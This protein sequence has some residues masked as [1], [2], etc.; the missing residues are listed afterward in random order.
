MNYITINHSS[1]TPLY[2]QLKASIVNAINQGI[3]SSG[4]KVPTEEELCERF[5]I[6]RPVIRQAYS[7]LSSEGILHRVKGIGTFIREKE[8]Q[9]HF[10]QTISTYEEDIRRVGLSPEVKI[11]QREIIDTAGPFQT[12]LNLP[13]EAE[14][15]H[16]RFLYLGNKVPFCLVDS[17]VPHALFPFLLS[18]ALESTPLYQLLESDYSRIIVQAIRTVDAIIASD[19]EAVTLNI[20]KGAAIHEVKT[21]ATDQNETILEYSRA[22]YPGERNAFDVIIYR[23]QP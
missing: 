8:I 16:I 20:P 10:F 21:I 5:G 17:Y 9:S 18:K 3:L 1:P 23:Q 22:C 12:L 4:D 2:A 13:P 15:I 7:E 6:S 11:L 19:K 14:V